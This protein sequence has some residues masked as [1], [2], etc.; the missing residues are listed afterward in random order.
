MNRKNTVRL[1]ESELKR[2]ITKSVKNIL[3]EGGTSLAD[4]DR[5]RSMHK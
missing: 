5:Y 1:T 2:V 4:Y 3:K